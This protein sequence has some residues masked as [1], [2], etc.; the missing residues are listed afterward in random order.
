MPYDDFKL[1]CDIF[2]LLPAQKKSQGWK[3]HFELLG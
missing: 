2:E 3:I 1:F